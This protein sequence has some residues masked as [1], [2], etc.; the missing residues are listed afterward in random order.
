MTR[1]SI[2]VGIG[3]M[4]VGSMAYALPT[5]QDFTTLY[6]AFAGIVIATGGFVAINHDRLRKHM[7]HMNAI[8]AAMI[9]VWA[10][11]RCVPDAFGHKHG[12]IP[13][14]A[15][16][17]TLALAAVMLHYAIKSF[18]SVRMLARQEEESM[19]ALETK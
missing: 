8:A 15:D 12:N 11:L 2:L 3:L 1:I 10:C 17:D 18:I 13:L 7:M 5:V 19:N 9:L 6:S 16:L 14:I 4:L